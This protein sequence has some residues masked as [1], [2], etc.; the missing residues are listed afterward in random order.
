MYG[1]YERWYSEHWY[2]DS[3]PQ[4]QLR[5]P[6]VARHLYD[7]W[8][9]VAPLQLQIQPIT[10]PDNCVNPCNSISIIKGNYDLAPILQIITLETTS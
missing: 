8:V 9:Q 3:D 7:A 5:N 1:Y 2:F 6:P 10:K 4:I